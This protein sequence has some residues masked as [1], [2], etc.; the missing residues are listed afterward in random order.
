MKAGPLKGVIYRLIFWD[1]PNKL[2]SSGDRVFL[3]Q[4]F[5]EPSPVE[6]PAKPANAEQNI[7]IINKSVIVS[8]Y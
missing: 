7:F 5:T 6:P 8:F 4:M 1:E 3:G 2:I